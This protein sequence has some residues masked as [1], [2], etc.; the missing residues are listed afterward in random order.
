MSQ[1]R[2]SIWANNSKKKGYSQSVG[3]Y[4]YS[5]AAD[6][7]FKLTSVKTGQTR[8]YESPDAA[9]ADGWFITKRGK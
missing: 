6:R 3:S 1:A 5:K 7:F 4:G 9:Q 8:V 2:G